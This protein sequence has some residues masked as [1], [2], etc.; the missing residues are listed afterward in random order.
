VQPPQP[1]DDAAANLRSTAVDEGKAPLMY[2]KLPDDIESRHVL[3]MDPILPGGYSAVRAIE[4]L[5]VRRPC[6]AVASGRS[7]VHWLDGTSGACTQLSHMLRLRA[8]GGQAAGSVCLSDKRQ[9]LILSTWAL[10]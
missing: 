2:C 4:A 10:S 5:L 8:V 6:C 1:V 7:T 9:R 3:L